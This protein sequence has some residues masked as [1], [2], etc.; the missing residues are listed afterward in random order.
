MQTQRFVVIP[1]DESERDYFYSGNDREAQCVGHVRGDFG[2]GGNEY[3][4]S[5]WP[6]EGVDQADE[7]FHAEL[8]ALIVSLRE[9]LLKD[10]PAMRR[11]IQHHP[12]LVLEAGDLM[13]YGYRVETGKHVYYFRCTPYPG[14]YDFYVYAYQREVSQ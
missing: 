5:F 7:N 9:S 6:H 8:T 3:Y 13:S 4:A 12:T 2:R 11:Y 14:V 1:A 10:R